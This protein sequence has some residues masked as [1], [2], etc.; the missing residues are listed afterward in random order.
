MYDFP[1][2]RT[3]MI[4][5]RLFHSLL[6]WCCIQTSSPTCSSLTVVVCVFLYHTDL[7]SVWSLPCMLAC[8]GVRLWLRAGSCCFCFLPQN[9]WLGETPSSL[10][11]FLQAA[12]AAAKLS[13]LRAHLVTKLLRFFTAASASPFLCFRGCK[14]KITHGLS[15]LY[16]R[17][18]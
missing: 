6:S 3:A 17:I 12:T 4:F 14:V 13:L 11:M 18:L 15:Y 5:P 10:G 2:A 1:P 8:A 7:L 16:C 9:S